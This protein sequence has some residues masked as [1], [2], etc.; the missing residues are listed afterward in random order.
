MVANFKSKFSQ[1]LDLAVADVDKIF[2]QAERGD[3]MLANLNTY[4]SSNGNG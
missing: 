2:S 3:P 1:V 4:P